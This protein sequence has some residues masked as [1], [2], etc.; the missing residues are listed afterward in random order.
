MAGL[1]NS[2]PMD[3]VVFNQ[4]VRTMVTARSKNMELSGVVS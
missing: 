4:P 3:F 1:A 2:F